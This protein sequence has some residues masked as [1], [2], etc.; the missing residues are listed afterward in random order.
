ME[1]HPHPKKHPK[2]AWLGLASAGLLA[3]LPA[4]AQFVPGSGGSIPV[5]A[6][7]TDPV[8]SIG[9]LTVYQTHRQNH[10]FTS[11][12]HPEM[13]LEFFPPS[14]FSA[15]AYVLQRSVNGTSGWADIPWDMDVLRTPSSGTDNFSITPDG[16]FYYRLRVEG[17]PRDGQFSNVVHVPV[18]M[19]DT[20]FAGWSVDSSMFLTGTMFPWLGHGMEASFTVRK[21]LDDSIVADAV[22]L[23][24]YRVNP[25]TSEMTA[26]PGATNSLYVTTIDDVGGWLLFCRATADEVNAGGFIQIQAGGGVKIPNKA[27]VNQFTST[28]FRLNLHKSVP[29][30]APAD[31]ML[32]YF[33]ADLVMNVDIPIDSVTPVGGNA[34][35]QIAAAIPDGVEQVSLSNVSEVWALGAE[36]SHHPGMPPMFFEFLDIAIEP[37]ITLM[38][39]AGKVLVDNRGTLNFGAVKVKKRSAPKVFTIRND[40]GANLTVS[41]VRATG[42]GAKHYIV[43]NPP[44]RTLTPGA[45]TTFRVTLAPRAKGTASA[46][47]QVRSN[48]G[49]ENPFDVNLTGRGK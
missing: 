4:H 41:S 38:Q 37:E 2:I 16:E 11:G 3:L 32:T 36:V 34:S 33:D 47:L 19:I 49:D 1:I 27:Y 29:T 42:G 25:R 43:T 23:Q 21:L 8:D 46:K 15:D 22:D 12:T 9:G 48:D 6:P 24:W 5:I 10:V 45:S 18:S 14:E 7:F 30:L 35:F 39:P 20:R 17:G 31:L 44:I 28:G 26:I 40:G 13:D